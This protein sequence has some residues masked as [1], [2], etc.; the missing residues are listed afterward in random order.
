MTPELRQDLK[1]C[2]EISYIRFS[3]LKNFFYRIIFTFLKIFFKII[4]SY[5]T[6]ALNKVPKNLDAPGIDPV[7]F[8][9]SFTSTQGEKTI[10]GVQKLYTIGSKFLKLKKSN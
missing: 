6:E 8:N 10:F 4:L 9:P 3:F 1:I 5:D 2:S 7:Q